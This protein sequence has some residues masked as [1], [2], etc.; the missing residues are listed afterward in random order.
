LAVLA[1]LFAILP[2][3]VARDLDQKGTGD[4]ACQME[5]QSGQMQTLNPEQQQQAEKMVANPLF[6]TACP[7]GLVGLWIAG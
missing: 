4:H 2:I 5:S 3:L 1:M 6:T 7:P